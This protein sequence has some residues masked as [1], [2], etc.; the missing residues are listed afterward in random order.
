MRRFDNEA[1]NLQ[2]QGQLGLWIPSIGQEAA[3]VGSGTPP[4]RRTTSSR[5]TASTSSAASAASTRCASSGCSAALSHGG[6]VPSRDRQLPPLH[7]RDRLADAARDGLRDGHRVRRLNGE[8]RRSAEPDAAV[9]GLLRRRRVQPGRRERG[10]R[11]RRELS[12]PAGLLPAEQPLG[13]LGAG[14]ARSRARRCTCAAGVRHPERA[15]RRQR[16]ARQLRGHD[17]RTS[18]TPAAARDRG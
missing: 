10:V 5:P 3:Q 13:D 1:G 8:R 17:R 14:R 6:W 9:H 12:D 7:A 16:C 2:R 11:L 4:S 18:T 15:D